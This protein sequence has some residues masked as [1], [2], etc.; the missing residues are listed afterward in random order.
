MSLEPGM[1]TDG[2]VQDAR[3]VP[4]DRSPCLLNFA[5]LNRRTLPA[6]V[7]GY[8]LNSDQDRDSECGPFTPVYGCLKPAEK[9]HSAANFAPRVRRSLRVE[10]FFASSMGVNKWEQGEAIFGDGAREWRV[11]IKRAT[12]NRRL[13]SLCFFVPFPCTRRDVWL[14]SRRAGLDG[15]DNFARPPAAETRFRQP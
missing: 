15:R 2:R 8:R 10:S 11:P 14:S 6:P 1:I 5:R 3:G 4:G 13:C 9:R 7:G 12:T